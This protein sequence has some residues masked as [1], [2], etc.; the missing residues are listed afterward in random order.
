M[1]EERF[2]EN[3]VAKVKISFSNKSKEEQDKVFKDIAQAAYNLC[4]YEY[5]R[6]LKEDTNEDN[7]NA[8]GIEA[9]S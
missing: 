7:N 3:E 8:G 2:Y 6:N 1:L 5:L 9:L 4:K